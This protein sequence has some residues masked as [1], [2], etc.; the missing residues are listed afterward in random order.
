[1]IE[2]IVLHAYMHARNINQYISFL[3]PNKDQN[4]LSSKTLLPSLKHHRI[5]DLQTFKMTRWFFWPNIHKN[6]SCLQIIDAV[7]TNVLSR[8]KVSKSTTSLTDK[9]KTSNKV[10]RPN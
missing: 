6:E 2:I 3:T 10:D 5:Q 4:S 1:M 9:Q 8:Q 7:H